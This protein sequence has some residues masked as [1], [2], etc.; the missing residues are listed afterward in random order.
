MSLLPGLFAVYRTAGGVLRYRP[1][2]ILAARIEAD[3]E[4]D[5]DYNCRC[6]NIA[7][8]AGIHESNP[9]IMD[10]DT[11]NVSGNTFVICCDASAS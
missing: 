6:L 3:D 1:V 2:F 5:D 4:L 7:A 10:K 9:E 11:V 8:A